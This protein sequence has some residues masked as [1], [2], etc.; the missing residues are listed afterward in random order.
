M[1]GQVVTIHAHAIDRRVPPGQ[2][3]GAVRHTDWVGDVKAVKDCAVLRD[4]VD[5]GGL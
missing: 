2:Q 5:I 3:A 4:F 1:R